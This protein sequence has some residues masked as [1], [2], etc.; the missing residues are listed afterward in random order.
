VKLS[1]P[2]AAAMVTSSG[3]PICELDAKIFDSVVKAMKDES[4]WEGLLK[5]FISEKS[6]SNFI[7]AYPHRLE[8]G[9]M[10]Y[11]NAKVQEKVFPD[12]TRSDVLLIDKNE[13]PIVVECKQG[14]PTLKNLKQLRGYIKNVK[15]ETGRRPRGILV[16]GGA[17]SL[18]NEVRRQVTRDPQLKIIR[19]S[20]N[21]SFVPCA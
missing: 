5:R 4:N 16:H 21:V 3:E 14:E 9:L 6:L 20:M 15:K 19:Y 1:A 13:T 17:V 18:R 2:S 11:P 12:G 10:P 8:D 7:A